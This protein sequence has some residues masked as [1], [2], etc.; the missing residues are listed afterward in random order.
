MSQLKVGSVRLWLFEPERLALRGKKPGR[1]V[2]LMSPML[3]PF[4]EGFRADWIVLGSGRGSPADLLTLLRDKV[5]CG[6]DSWSG[7][8]WE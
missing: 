5:Y 1:Q 4:R 6:I 2:V 7:S 3:W 8:D